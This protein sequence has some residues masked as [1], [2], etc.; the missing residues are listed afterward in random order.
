ML[1]IRQ[2]Q[3]MVPRV[4]KPPPVAREVALYLIPRPNCRR[5]EPENTPFRENEKAPG[6]LRYAGAFGGGI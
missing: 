5:P 1:A 6:D 3:V 4:A 2:N